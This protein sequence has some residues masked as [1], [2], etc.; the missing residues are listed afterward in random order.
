MTDV[1]SAL[2]SQL[3]EV[4]GQ[5]TQIT[6]MIQL[7]HESTHKRIDDLRHSNDGRFEGVEGR[8]GVLE[9]NERSTAIRAGGSGG[10]AGGIVAAGIEL[11]KYLAARP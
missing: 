1:E 3:G 4:K 8:V 2:L 6:Q 11:I 7:N 9:V 5:L 10:I